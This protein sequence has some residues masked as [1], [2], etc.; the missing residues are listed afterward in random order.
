[1]SDTHYY[2]VVRSSD[3]SLE[4]RSHKYIKRER[5]A[6]GKYR[7]WYPGDIKSGSSDTSLANR[8]NNTLR[9][10]GKKLDAEYNKRT[11]ANLT[12]E[13]QY[14]KDE[15]DMLKLRAQETGYRAASQVNA[16][17]AKYYWNKIKKS[18]DLGTKYW[19]KLAR[20]LTKAASNKVKE[21]TTKGKYYLK[22]LITDIKRV[23]N[24]TSRKRIT[25]QRIG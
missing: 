8:L 3:N 5:T 12:K 17:K 6:S 16:E 20:S 4:H 7:Y 19:K 2:G 22:Y 25:G 24:G 10:A 13:Q 21:Y 1:M 9:S 15:A 14:Y 23:N 18:S 11:S